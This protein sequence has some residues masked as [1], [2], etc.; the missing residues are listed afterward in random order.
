M[1]DIE[2][3]MTDGNGVVWVWGWV[4]C[5]VPGLL[6]LQWWP[7]DRFESAAVASVKAGA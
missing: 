6:N 5:G 3:V 1:F 4:R 2:E 7:W